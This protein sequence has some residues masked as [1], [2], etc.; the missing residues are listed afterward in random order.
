MVVIFKNMLTGTYFPLS[1]LLFHV[2]QLTPI[3]F[4]QVSKSKD[5]SGSWW[6]KDNHNHTSELE[7]T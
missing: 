6:E 4:W 2:Y 1:H 3:V 5:R 7:D